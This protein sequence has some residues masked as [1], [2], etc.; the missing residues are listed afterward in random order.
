[1]GLPIQYDVGVGEALL[2]PAALVGHH[3]VDPHELGR[4]RKEQVGGLRW[5]HLRDAGTD[6]EQDDGQEDG[7]RDSQRIPHSEV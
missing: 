7:R 4:D 5:R 1:M 2:R 3:H 6:G